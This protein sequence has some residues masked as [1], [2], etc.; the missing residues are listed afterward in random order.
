MQSDVSTTLSL[1]ARTGPDARKSH[2]R[3]MLNG[4]IPVDP[5]TGSGG[6]AI[7]FAKVFA[8]G[9]IKLNAVR[10]DPILAVHAKQTS[11][12]DEVGST[13]A[14]EGEAAWD[15]EGI[16]PE[17]EESG[18]GRLRQAD[19]AT[20]M[21]HDQMAEA[22]RGA[23]ESGVAPKNSRETSWSV[24]GSHFLHNTNVFA[25]VRESSGDLD[26]RGEPQ[27]RIDGHQPGDI[28]PNFRPAQD[29]VSFGMVSEEASVEAGFVSPTGRA[30]NDPS[31]GIVKNVMRLA[32]ASQLNPVE[33]A[34]HMDSVPSLVAS[35]D[36]EPDHAR[37]P[38]RPTAV[39]RLQPPASDPE[40]TGVE[41]PQMANVAYHIPSSGP[42]SD[43][44][45]DSEIRRSTRAEDGL[46]S[47]IPHQTTDIPVRFGQVA[48]KDQKYALPVDG[49]LPVDPQGAGQ[50]PSLSGDPENTDAR[51]LTK[52]DRTPAGTGRFNTAAPQEIE[53]NPGG[54]KIEFSAAPEIAS[55]SGDRMHPPTETNGHRGPAPEPLTQLTAT[56]LQSD[57][58]VR[59]VTSNE[60][61]RFAT[62]EDALPSDMVSTRRGTA[63]S[64]PF[65]GSQPGN[66][67][68]LAWSQKVV[69]IMGNE[70]GAK[71]VTADQSQSSQT[72]PTTFVPAINA[73]I[74][75]DLGQSSGMAGGGVA[76]VVA[77]VRSPQVEAP[78]T[79]QA[80]RAAPDT[81]GGV[82]LP[83][84]LPKGEGA[85]ETPLGVLTGSD[86]IAPAARP[87]EAISTANGMPAQDQGQGREKPDVPTTMAASDLGRAQEPQTKAA[88][89]TDYSTPGSPAEPSSRGI[90][91]PPDNASGGDPAKPNALQPGVETQSVQPRSELAALPT[92]D[93]PHQS[94]TAPQPAT[95]M[96]NAMVA[97]DVAQQLS[98]VTRSA[99]G[100]VTELS[101]RPD[102]LGHVRMRMTGGDGQIVLQI[103]SER[104]ETHDLMR[105]HIDIV[106][107]AFRELGYNDIAFEFSFNGR[108]DR[109]A[110]G[111]DDIGQVAEE[112][113]SNATEGADAPATAPQAERL[114]LGATR[115]DI[116]L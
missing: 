87:T 15:A 34:D 64:T 66:L 100:E 97:R 16:Q 84:P 107:R 10:S 75:T 33:T 3:V 8:D 47:V 112:P 50:G 78:P 41:S 63:L 48:S 19:V 17:P 32:D 43:L 52:T 11:K 57:Q 28:I 65:K 9:A 42:T 83:Q 81:T 13:V 14:A 58:E 22:D 36:D 96:Q 91:A 46:R 23:S 35:V 76:D 111:G 110:A 101:L 44:S 98:L 109:N 99:A 88:L 93:V 70:A 103:L 21:S 102:E 82:A 45:G 90:A 114:A 51:G 104:P 89:P 92:R 69:Q 73:P 37:D 54:A 86:W 4:L 2:S 27:A 1:T 72:P 12:A 106:E 29:P 39:S 74:A 53:L 68:E 31:V 55:G 24:S 67:A 38:S 71:P 56:T 94:V 6:A 113:Q 77:P 59:L 116:R 80:H 85:R 30:E 26:R 40:L 105:R 115:L 18:T 61:Q 7:D 60:P 25:P 95:Q 79:P 49:Q 5:K 108:R 20:A 62:T